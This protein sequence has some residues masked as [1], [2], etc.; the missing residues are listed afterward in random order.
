MTNLYSLSATE[1]LNGYRTGRIS[2]VE[3]TRSCL[4]RIAAVDETFN[5]FCLVDERS[6]L[7]SARE[8]ESRWVKGSPLGLVD[9]LPTSVKDLML[10]K[11]WPTL[12]GSKAVDPKGSAWDEDSPAVARL[13]EQGAV[14]L[15]KTTTSEFGHKGATDSP[16]TGITRNPWNPD[17]TPGGSSGGAGTAAAAGM[18]PLNLGSDGGGS[19][20]I[21]ASFCGVFGMKPGYAVVPHPSVITGPLVTDG[22]ITRT[23]P[24]AALML[25]VMSGWDVRQALP[26]PQKQPDFMT[27][28]DAGIS[29]K[30]IGYVPTI[31]NAPVDAEVAATVASAAAVF[32]DLGAVV[33]ETDLEMP[34][35][36]DLYVRILAVGTAL[37][38]KPF[39]QAQLDEM[40]P[41]LVVLGEMGKRITAMEYVNDFHH[42]R[43][44]LITTMNAMFERFDLMVMPTM[45][46]TAF[47]VG[48][49]Y[50]G[51]Q[52][53]GTW[54]ADWTPFTHPFNLTSLPA[55]SIPCGLSGEGL[56]IG[57]QIVG[58]VGY[59]LQVLQAAR[60]FETAGKEGHCAVMRLL[61]LQ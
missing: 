54:K 34:G 45:P 16:L 28:L 52:I 22:P 58:Q 20:R 9:G 11:G 24:D 60:A 47:P 53:P 5:A 44:R 55:C 33:E 56:P 23:V 61:P 57:L 17:R 48:Q 8:S 39:S 35:E 49:D 4:D 12:C 51:P 25:Q 26:A 21:P 18:A 32:A 50:P 29:G 13:R 10:T 1:L 40:D 2:P 42:M 43:G 59:D 19:V 15:G 46:A 3:A 27:T 36:V 37:M 6:A 38:L 7:R 30:R 31:S 41:A 14:F